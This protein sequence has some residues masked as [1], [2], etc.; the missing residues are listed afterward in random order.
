MPIS[1]DSSGDAPVIRISGVTPPDEA[2]ELLALLREHPGI[3]IDLSGLDHLHT[4]LLQMLL[5]TQAPVSAWPADG[6]WRACLEQE[7]NPL[8]LPLSGDSF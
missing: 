2:D 8:P 1:L 5:A 6:F 7:T 4:A 3:P